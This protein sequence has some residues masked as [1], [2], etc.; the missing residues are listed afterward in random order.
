MA[1]PRRY[2][3]LWGN[4]VPTTV[5]TVLQSSQRDNSHLVT[6][7]VEGWIVGLRYYRDS[8]T[9]GSWVGL[10]RASATGIVQAACSFKPHVSGDPS[11][12][13]NAYIHPRFHVN[14][15]ETWEITIETIGQFWTST[16]SALVAGPFVSGDLTIARDN[17]AGT[18][19]FFN[20]TGSASNARTSGAGAMWGIDVLFQPK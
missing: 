16:P 17:P 1:A 15:G 18:T 10:V 19:S 4:A 3:T 20:T 9:R 2:E 12:W 11:A 8:R 7:A 5:Q 14:A 6:F 13:E